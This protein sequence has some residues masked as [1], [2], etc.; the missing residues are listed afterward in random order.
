M[1]TRHDEKQNPGSVHW[2]GQARGARGPGGASFVVPGNLKD[3]CDDRVLV[4]ADDARC[5]ALLADGATGT[6]RGGLAADA[7][8]ERLASFDGA[9]TDA[10]GLQK[11]FD[12]ADRDAAR[13]GGSTTGIAVVLKNGA[14][15]GCSVGDSVA[16]LIRAGGSFEELT[17]WQRRKPRIGQ[18]SIELEVFD[19]VELSLGCRV[20]MV[21]DGVLQLGSY[22][23]IVADALSGTPEHCLA[24]L[25]ARAKARDPGVQTDDCS[26]ILLD[27]DNIW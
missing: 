11:Q 5:L 7:F 24:N 27:C 16:F 6:G 21:S 15:I 9:P 19:P 12:L 14:L 8:I 25:V 2:T 23:S 4:L 18:S 20:L 17:R 1:I 26:G 22:Q 13:T 10:A 3:Q